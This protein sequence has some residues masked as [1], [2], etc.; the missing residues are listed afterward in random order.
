[1][2][3]CLYERLHDLRVEPDQITDDDIPDIVESEDYPIN[4]FN[5]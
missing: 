2:L 1:M 4:R 5:A 3:I